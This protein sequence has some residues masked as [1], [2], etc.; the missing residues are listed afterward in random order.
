MFVGGIAALLGIV[1]LNHLLKKKNRDLFD[2]KVTFVFALL[3]LGYSCFALAE[4][5]WYLL[6]E[7]FNQTPMVSMPDFYWVL[8]SVSLLLAF[9]SF[10]IYMHKRHG[11]VS[12]SWTLLTFGVILVGIVLYY[13]LGIDFSQETFGKAFLGYFYPL[14]SSLIVVASLSVYLFLEKISVFRSNLFLFFLANIA[15]LAGDLLYIDY[16]VSGVFGLGGVVS[17]LSYI[18]AYG[19][20]AF[21]FLDF[22]FKTQRD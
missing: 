20:C 21:S 14:V 6:F 3:A 19:L 18:V 12:K 10:S 8:G 16:G 15:F 4:L 7:L 1:L 17:E 13:V 2:G 22:L 11:E 9:V 5:S